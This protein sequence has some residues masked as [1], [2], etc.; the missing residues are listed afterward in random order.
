MEIREGISTVCIVNYKTL[1]I[2]KLCLDNLKKIEAGLPFKVM[3]IDNDSADESLEYLKSLNWIQLVERKKERINDGGHEHG[4]ALDLGL[5]LCDTE[6]FISLHS[7]TIIHKD[8]WL[9]FLIEKFQNDPKVACVGGDKIDF[10]PAWKVLIKKMGDFKTFKRKILRTP[11]T[12][13]IYRYYNRTNCSAYRTE[14]LKKEN[15]SF[16][17]WRDKGLT[18]G[19]KL[20]FE[21]EDRGY[22]TVGIPDSKMKNYMVHLGHATQAINSEFNIPDRTKKK[23]FKAERK[24]E[25]LAK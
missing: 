15:L 17:M 23:Y 24:L 4:A 25:S 9:K 16:L 22:K 6:F 2:T 1:K 7:D 8:G 11:D 18:A 19:K 5:E 21:L 20:F 3:V 12:L 13:G 10:V 14:V